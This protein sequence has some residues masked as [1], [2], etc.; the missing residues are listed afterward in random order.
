MESNT[1]ESKNKMDG[2]MYI[3][4]NP[5]FPGIKKVGITQRSPEIRLKEHNRKSSKAKIEE[6]YLWKDLKSELTRYNIADWKIVFKKKVYNV[7]RKEK[8][9]NELISRHRVDIGYGKECYAISLEK[10]KKYY[11]KVQFIEDQIENKWHV[12]MLK[13]EGRYDEEQQK[14]EF[15][16]SNT[17]KYISDISFIIESDDPPEKFVGK[18]SYIYQ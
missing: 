9:L 11:E 1:S 12:K 5:T 14:R 13:A 7:K 15:S 4:E 2:C 18:R 3:A 6:F 8:I 16:I 17:W 10:V